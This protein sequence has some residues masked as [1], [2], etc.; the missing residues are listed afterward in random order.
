[1]LSQVGFLTTFSLPTIQE[2]VD[3]NIKFDM[4]KNNAIEN[5]SKWD[6][7]DKEKRKRG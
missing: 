5:R 1:M 6:K 4:L 3:V 2:L 7:L